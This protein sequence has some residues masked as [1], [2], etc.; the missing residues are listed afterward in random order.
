MLRALFGVLLA[1]VLAT[2]ANATWK[3]EYGKS[4][5]PVQAWFKAA[6]TTSGA[7]ERL[8]IGI[9][10]EQAERLMTK[11][12]A[13]PGGE[14]AYYPDPA[15]TRKGCK[16]LPINNDVVHE[17]ELHALDPADDGL[18]EFEQMRREGVL[19]IY[20]GAP[21]CFWPPKEGGI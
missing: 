5:A 16:L 18:P 17:D 2:S 20:N 13:S 6:R 1:C 7:F 9:C 11:F 8:G 10:C 3:P 15:C 12:V 19:F 4:P 14:W 21:S